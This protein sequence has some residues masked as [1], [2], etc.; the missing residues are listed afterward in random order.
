VKYKNWK[1]AGNL[2]PLFLFAVSSFY[3]KI[4]TCD[5]VDLFSENKLWE[6]SA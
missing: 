4:K 2:W 6:K 1:E 5:K 3:D